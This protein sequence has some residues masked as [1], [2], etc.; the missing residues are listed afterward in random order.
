LCASCQKVDGVHRAAGSI[1]TQFKDLTER[2]ILPLAISNEKE[3]S[4][5]YRDFAEGLAEHFLASAAVMS[6]MA[7]EEARHRSRLFDLYRTAAET[8]RDAWPAFSLA[9]PEFMVME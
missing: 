1:A 9:A 5:I 2:Q 4:R 3:G 6:G 7:E 8:T